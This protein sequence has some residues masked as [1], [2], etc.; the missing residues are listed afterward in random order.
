MVLWLG[1]FQSPETSLNP[2]IQTPDGAPITKL[3]MLDIGKK[4]LSIVT[5]FQSINADQAELAQEIR[6]RID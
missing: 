2:S 1:S 5:I 4:N 6:L 3:Q